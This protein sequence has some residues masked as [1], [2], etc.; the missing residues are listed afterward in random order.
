MTTQPVGVPDAVPV[1]VTIT[2]QIPRQ[3]I[4]D[5]LIGA[6]EGGSGYWCRIVGYAAPVRIA[7]G[8]INGTVYR[9][10][11]YP[12]TG[13]AV[14]VQVTGD[15]DEEGDRHTLDGAACIRGLSV[16]AERYPR[17]WGN[18][19]NENDDAETADVYLQCCLLGEVIYG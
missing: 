3:R 14:I 18:F 8:E 15:D 10:C 4:A 11:D 1:T 2:Q 13:G 19:V 5:L 6:F 16:M 7:V 17:H 9:H 12:L